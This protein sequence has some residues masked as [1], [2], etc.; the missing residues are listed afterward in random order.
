M[1]VLVGVAI[2]YGYTFIPLK[3]HKEF[4]QLYIIV[5]Y[6]GQLKLQKLFL[7]LC[8]TELVLHYKTVW[9]FQPQLLVSF[10]NYA[11]IYNTPFT[12]LPLN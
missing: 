7:L 12:L 1:S 4:K 3:H 11:Y 5:F 10:N 8:I 6:K 2:I 9:L